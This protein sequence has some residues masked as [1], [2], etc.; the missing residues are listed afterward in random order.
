MELGAMQEPYVE[1][2]ELGHVRHI[3]VGLD[4][5]TIGR[6]RDNRLVLGD[7]MASRFHCLISKSKKGYVLRDLNSSNGTLL[8]GNVTKLTRLING[9]E[10]RIGQARLLFFAPNGEAEGPR[11][12]SD[13]MDEI[14]R[15]SKTVPLGMDPVRETHA[16]QPPK[17]VY[18]PPVQEHIGLDSLGLAPSHMPGDFGYD[19]RDVDLD[20]VPDREN[21][22]EE[23]VAEALT[24]DMLLEDGEGAI[25]LEGGPVGGNGSPPASYAPIPMDDEVAGDRAE[26]VE[27]VAAAAMDSESAIEQVVNSLPDRSFSEADIA[28]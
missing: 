12:N 2:H 16:P 23:E 22:P 17:T 18:R 3:P 25:P 24:D 21:V 9:D 27:D 5:L 20:A 19:V 28:L 13:L 8:N 11:D 6:H 10:V 15:Q 7:T 26:L 4:P 14:K 1:V